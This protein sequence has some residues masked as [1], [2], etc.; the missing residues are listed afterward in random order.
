LRI[1]SLAEGVEAKGLRDLLTDAEKLMK[2]GNFRS[3]IDKYAQAQQVAPNNPLILLG[4]AQA[5]LAASRYVSA[6]EH[7]RQAVAADPA[8]LMGQYDLESFI[9][10]DRLQ[11]LVQDLKQM[12]E[13]E[14]GSPR[15]KVLLAYIAYGTPGLESAAAEFL[16]EAAERAGRPD[17]LVEAMRKHWVLPEAA[18]D[19]PSDQNK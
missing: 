9:G 17:P 6:D 14:A 19:A 10:R 4:R 7:L 13:S 11:F 15:P 12:A 18:P 1:K 3:A 5:E 8:L 2:E 16:N